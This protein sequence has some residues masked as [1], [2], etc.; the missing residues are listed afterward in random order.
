MLTRYE[1]A[2]GLVG[3]VDEPFSH[4]AQ[5]QGDRRALELRGWRAKEQESWLEAV[6]RARN[7]ASDRRVD[8]RNRIQSAVRFHV[9]QRDALCGRDSGHRRNLIENQIL[10]GPRRQLHHPTS[11]S[12]QVWIPGMRSHGDAVCPGQPHR[13]PEDGRIAGVQAGRNAG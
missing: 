8:R 2:I 6:D 12:H 4:E 3:T 10:D 11:E 7:R 1:R 13:L 9:L 5:P